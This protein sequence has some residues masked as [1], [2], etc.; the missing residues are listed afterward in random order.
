MDVI[1]VVDNDKRWWTYTNKAFLLHGY[2][3]RHPN[4]SCVPTKLYGT[5]TWGC[6][7]NTIF[8]KDICSRFLPSTY[9]GH[10]V[11]QRSGIDDACQSGKMVTLLNSLF[12]VFKIPIFWDSFYTWTRYTYLIL[13]WFN[14][15]LLYSSLCFCLCSYI[16]VMSFETSRQ[17]A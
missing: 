17:C 3:I 1:H 6:N 16:T 11:L 13:L 9:A 14:T 7:N 2:T 12:F 15:S 5:S 10:V 8:Q 4:S